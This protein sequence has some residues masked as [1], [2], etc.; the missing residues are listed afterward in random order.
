[1]CG[2]VAVGSEGI[3][4]VQSIV[5]FT[6]EVVPL[7]VLDKIV[8]TAIVVFGGGL[9]LAGLSVHITTITPEQSYRGDCS[10]QMI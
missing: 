10:F 2:V 5:S 8:E 9:F 3:G 1:M 6:F 7:E 4:G